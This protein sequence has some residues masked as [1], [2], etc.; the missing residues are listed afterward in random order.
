MWL[1]P[2]SGWKVLKRKH[3]L[4]SLGYLWHLVHGEYS[5]HISSVELLWSF[6]VENSLGRQSLSSQTCSESLTHVG[7]K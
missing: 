1:S 6:P 5:G 2:T 7:A 4:F 3:H